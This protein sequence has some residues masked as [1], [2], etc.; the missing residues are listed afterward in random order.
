M[1]NL[2]DDPKVQALLQKAEDSAAKAL[3]KAVKAETKR[4]TDA[5]KTAV[6]E[7]IA[8]DEDKSFVKGAK[9]ALAAAVGAAKSAA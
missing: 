9:A 7:V 1:A 8:G 4:V 5:I 6:G 2:K 3:A